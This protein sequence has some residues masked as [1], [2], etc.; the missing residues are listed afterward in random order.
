MQHMPASTSHRHAGPVVTW[1][2]LGLPSH[3]EVSHIALT[4]RVAGLLGREY[5]GRLEDYELSERPFCVPRTTLCGSECDPRLPGV[6]ETDFLGGW[7]RHPLACTKAIVHPLVPGEPMPENWPASFANAA[8]ALTLPGFTAFTRGGA[9]RAGTLLLG[10]GDVRIKLVNASGGTDQYVARSSAELVD[11]VDALNHVQE[12]PNVGVVVEENLTD[13]ITFSVGQIS[14]GGMLA[15]YIGEQKLTSNNYGQEVY[16]G[17]TLRMYRGQWADLIAA[18]S[19]EDR[20]VCNLGMRFDQ[21]AEAHL[22]LVASRRN[23]DIVRGRDRRGRL[24]Y[25]VLEQSWRVGGASGAE[26]AGLNAFARDPGLSQVCASTVELYGGDSVPPAGGEVYFH[27]IDP[28]LGPLLK[29]SYVQDQ[30]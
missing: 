17:S 9:V 12:G 14:L 22:G 27:G 26:I 20:A 16:G 25:A 7:V 3:D 28:D 23:Y 30:T 11:I 13:V 1:G 4:R 5:A 2:C 8:A 15:T 18:L 19:G 24:K 6:T 10:N 29:Y 21:M